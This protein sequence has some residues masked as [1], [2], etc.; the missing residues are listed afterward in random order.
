MPCARERRPEP[1]P[2]DPA[3]VCEPPPPADHHLA[4]EQDAQRL[5]A[6]VATLPKDQ[7]QLLKLAFFED[8]SHST[9]AGELDLPLGTVK[10]RLRL[11]MAKLRAGL[12][13]AL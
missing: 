10:S 4:A 3:L 13:E 6:A 5:R 1:D 8:K 9:I 12:K 11:A 7:A 2:N